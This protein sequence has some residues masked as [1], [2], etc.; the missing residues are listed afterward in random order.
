MEIGTKV[1]MVN[2]YEARK[3]PDKVWVT[4]SNPW[5]LGHGAKVVLLEGKSGGFSVDCLKIVEE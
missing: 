1:I 5:E 2:C 4:R 3:Y